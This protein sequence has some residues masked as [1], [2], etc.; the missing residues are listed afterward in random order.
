MTVLSA[1]HERQRAALRAR[2]RA[3]EAELLPVY[4]LLPDRGLWAGPAGWAFR[5][6]ID[7]L[8]E[9]I[10]AAWAALAAAEAEL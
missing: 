9:R 2:V 8:R 10:D 1:E 4:R 6:R 3:A 5:L 7:G